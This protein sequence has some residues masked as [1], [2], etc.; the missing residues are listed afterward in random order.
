MKAIQHIPAALIWQRL[1]ATQKAQLSE[2]LFFLTLEQLGGLCHDT[3]EN[4][5]L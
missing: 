4:S 1:P 2:R 3:S 5:S